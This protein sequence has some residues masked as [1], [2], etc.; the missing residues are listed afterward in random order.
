MAVPESVVVLFDVDTTLIDNDRIIDDLKRHIDQQLGARSRDHYFAIFEALRSELGYADCLGAL[1]RYRLEDQC[2][3]RLLAMSSFL[4][5]YPCADRLYPGAL[6]VPT[7]ARTWGTTVILSDGDLVFQ[8]SKVKR[9]GLWDADEGRVLICVHKEEMLDNVERHYPAG[10]YIM[11]DDKI[12]ILTAMKE[13]W[14]DRSLPPSS[15][16]KGI[17][18]S[19]SGTS[20]HIPS[21][22]S[23]SRVSAVS[24]TATCAEHGNTRA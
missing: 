6:P 19:I 21:P 8:T 5:D 17:R 23:L 15:C 11:I 4:V 2:D 10:H 12:R 13:V 22:T 18:R 7:H 20:H 16:V 24:S 14:E 1:Q 3:P 9:S